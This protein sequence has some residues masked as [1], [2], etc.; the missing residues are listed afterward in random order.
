VV[1]IGAAR[2]EG[3]MVDLLAT[4]DSR[5]DGRGRHRIEL[6]PYGYRWFRSGGID[7]ADEAAAAPAQSRGAA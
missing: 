2:G 1:R 7:H 5:A 4:H 3:T 6:E